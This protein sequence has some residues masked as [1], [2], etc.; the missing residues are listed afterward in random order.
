M[1]IHVTQSKREIMMNIGVSVE[2]DDWTS[3]KNSYIWNPSTCGFGCNKTCTIGEYLDIKHFL[4]KKR[5]YGKL[6]L[7]YED[8]ISNAAETSFMDEK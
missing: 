4:C 7:A 6:V 8:E 3:C 5:L 2:L 1:K